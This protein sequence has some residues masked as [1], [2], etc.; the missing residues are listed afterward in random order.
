[1]ES[2]ELER[3]V[4]ELRACGFTSLRSENMKPVVDVAIAEFTHILDDP[5]ARRIFTIP[6]AQY[7]RDE[8]G[9]P[10]ELGILPKKSG[11]EKSPD[12]MGFF[13]KATR[14]TV[15]DPLKDRFHYAAR[16]LH[17]LRPEDRTK[18]ASFMSALDE[19]SKSA[20]SIVR[21]IA[22]EFDRVKAQHSRYKSYPGSLTERMYGAVAITRLLRYG[23]AFAKV[24]RDRDGFS[25]HHYS[26]HSGLY[27]FD[28]KKKA[29]GIE[30][31]SPYSRSVFTGEKFWAATRGLF[32]T[33]VPHGVEASAYIPPI[34]RFAIVTFIHIALTPADV[35]WL[36]E[37]VKEIEIDASLFKMEIVS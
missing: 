26:S 27:L 36:S 23:K 19:L 28:K 32:G 20:L 29:H 1:M 30:E 31:T 12:K 35:K 7:Q 17:L 11:E 10:Y 37:H 34:P 13:D 14:R 16:L 5:D 9:E 21:Q 3:V 6:E 8:L 15:D 33:A 24:H 22:E 4:T 18:Y 25:V 2:F